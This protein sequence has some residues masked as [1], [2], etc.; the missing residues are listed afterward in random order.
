MYQ[1][2]LITWYQEYPNKTF[3][4]VYN[5]LKFDTDK[6]AIQYLNDNYDIISEQFPITEIKISPIRNK[7]K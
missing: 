6:E 3:E 4:E 2:I 5:N 7:T 1:I